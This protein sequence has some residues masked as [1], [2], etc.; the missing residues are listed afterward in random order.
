[1][2]SR[3]PGPVRNPVLVAIDPGH[4]GTNLGAA[5]LV[6]G[7]YE[8]NVTLAL[9]ERV[10]ALL[11]ESPESPRSPVISVLL[12]RN[13]DQLVPIR[14]RA[15]C[16]AETGAQLFISLHANAVPPGVAPQAQNGYEIFVLGPREVEDDV[17][18]AAL[19]E[20]NDAR[21]AFAAHEVRAGAEQSIRLA[22][23]LATHLT[24]A[25]G[26]S[27]WRGVKQSGAA[28]DVLR[29]THTAAALVEVG[30]LSHPVEGTTLTTRAGREPIARALVSAIRA[31]FV[32]PA[33]SVEPLIPAMTSSALR[34]QPSS[35]RR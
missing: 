8:K 16:A 2:T 6:H 15:R 32:V 19:G 34:D 26:E 28:L 1:V 25:L 9:A 14:A 23:I 30:F 10:Q 35:A 7:V 21:A 17:V 11:A 13:S 33:G 18:L 12:C 27:G 3:A 20:R 31:F 22:G 29:G 4:G 5:G 24:H